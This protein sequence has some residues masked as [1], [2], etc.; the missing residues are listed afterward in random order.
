MASL[1]SETGSDTFS[2]IG[3]TL[4]MMFGLCLGLGAFEFVG[5]HLPRSD[6]PSLRFLQMLFFGAVGCTVLHLIGVVLYGFARTIGLMLLAG[7]AVVF[8]AGERLGATLAQ[9]A[10]RLLF[11]SAKL[12]LV[13]VVWPWRKFHAA[14]IAPW[15]ERRRQMAELRR[16][17]ADV[18]D[19][20]ATFEEFL[21]A[22]NGDDRANANTRDDA[23]QDTQTET[24]PA[25][26]FAAAAA[27]FGLATDGSFTNAAFKAAYRARMKKAHPD[28]SGDAA[29]ATKLNEAR[30][31]INAR[32]GWKR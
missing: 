6:S 24:A 8:D 18:K 14:M 32:K 22:F 7:L 12:A 17:Y 21:R 13:P 26:A 28:L 27:L 4:Y 2:F 5:I 29:L 30:D 15:L 25:D 19:Q 31:L 1:K 20:Y 11:A 23:R 16:L 9:F 10:M 3:W